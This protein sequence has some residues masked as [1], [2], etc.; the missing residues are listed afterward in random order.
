M[1]G[2]RFPKP[3]IPCRVRA[4]GLLGGKAAWICCTPVA[5]IEIEN[6]IK[7]MDVIVIL[8]YWRELGDWKQIHDYNSWKEFKF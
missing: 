4:T 2:G 8:G 5:M 3:K 1:F 7:A 6:P